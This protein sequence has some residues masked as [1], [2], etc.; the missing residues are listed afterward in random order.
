MEKQS[1]FKISEEMERQEDKD[2]LLPRVNTISSVLR[3]VVQTGPY[4][5]VCLITHLSCISNFTFGR[6]TA[7]VFGMPLSTRPIT[8]IVNKNALAQFEADVWYGVI[9][10]SVHAHMECGSMIEQEISGEGRKLKE[11]GVE[12]ERGVVIRPGLRPTPIDT[13]D[14][15]IRSHVNVGGVAGI[16]CS[17]LSCV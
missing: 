8:V 10:A 1:N 2:P 12:I 4:I 5:P 15:E 17:V 14:E 7:P 6:G 11:T 9:T 3:L 13:E 16:N